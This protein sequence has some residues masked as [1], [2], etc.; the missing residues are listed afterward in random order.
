[1]IRIIEGYDPAA[2]PIELDQ[3][4]RQRATVFGER[5]GWDVTIEE[6]RE[7]DAFDREDT[8]YLLSLDDR[9]GAVMGSLRLLPT[10]EPHMM[11]T[12][13][14]AMFP[15]FATVRSPTILECTRFCVDTEEPGQ[16]RMPNGLT[17]S[18]SELLL[19]IC[20]MGLRSGITQITGMFDRSMLPIYRRAGLRPAILAKVEHGPSV[21]MVGLWD[22][23][24]AVLRTMRAATGISE[25]VMAPPRAASY[26]PAA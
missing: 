6:G 17:R 16:T 3:M 22:V 14:A 8:L 24:E 21:L 9:D 10:V 19:G 11:D 5:L 12:I 1:M 25:S 23:S 13:F 15:E 4:F 7:I 26:L 20:E 18:T 2:V